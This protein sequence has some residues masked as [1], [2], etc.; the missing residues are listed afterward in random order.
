MFIIAYIALGATDAFLFNRSP[1]GRVEHNAQLAA[2]AAAER[3]GTS[4][5]P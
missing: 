3:E 1:F 5:M 2:L 4:H